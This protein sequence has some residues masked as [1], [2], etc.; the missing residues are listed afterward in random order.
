MWAN[1]LRFVG[2]EACTH[3]SCGRV[4]SCRSDAIRSRL[5]ALRRWRYIVVDARP[6]RAP[7]RG[8]EASAGRVGTA[9]GRDRGPVAGALRRGARR[10][11][12]RGARAAAG[13][14]STSSCRA[15]CPWSGTG[16]SPRSSLRRSRCPPSR[17][18]PPRSVG[19]AGPDA[20]RLHARVRARRRSSRCRCARTVCACSGKSATRVRDL[21]RLT[22]VS[23]EG[24]AMLVGFLARAGLATVAPDPSAPRG[25]AVS[26]TPKGLAAKRASGRLA[27]D[28]EERWRQRFGADAIDELGAGA[29]RDPRC[30]CGRRAAPRAGARASSRR[31]ARRAGPTSPRP[32]RRAA[33]P[34]CRPRPATRWCSTAADSRTAVDPQ[35]RTPQP[36]PSTARRA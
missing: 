31:M 25:Q 20:A 14:G 32:Q 1:Y 3:A 34:A 4:R 13:A 24:L 17:R 30:V 7:R 35:P 16:W 27:V 29:S 36:S 8:R 9:R 15:T 5:G 22:G 6:R 21:P 18:W 12:A 10:A 23:K 2:D 28:I 33:R 11:P 19:A 26:L